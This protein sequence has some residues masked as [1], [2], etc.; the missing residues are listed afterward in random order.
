[1]KRFTK[2]LILLIFCTFSLSAVTVHAAEN[3]NT[4]DTKDFENEPSDDTDDTIHILFIGNSLTSYGTN[5]LGTILE[6]ISE[7]QGKSIT[8]RTIAHGAAH[9]SYYAYPSEKYASYYKEVQLALLTE[10]WDYIVLQEYSKGSIECAAKK[11]LPAIETFQELIK[12]YQPNAEILLYMTHGYDNGTTTYVNGNHV[13]LTSARLQQYTQIAY[14][15]IGE[16]LGLRVVPVGMTFARFEQLHPEISLISA[17]KK[18]PRYEGYFL[19][20]C[21]FYKTIFD[22]TPKATDCLPNGCMLSESCVQKLYDTT[23]GSLRLNKSSYIMKTGQTYDLKATLENTSDTDTE[24]TWKSTSPSVVDVTSSG[25]ITSHKN[26]TALIIAKSK[27]GL[28]DICYVTVEDELLHKRGLLFATESYV[29]EKGDTLQVSPSRSAALTTSV[30]K[31]SSSRKSIA[32]IAGD[33]TVTA[34]SPGKTVITATDTET[35]KSASYTLF[36]RLTAPQKVTA[37]TVT[38]ASNKSNE[39]NIKISWS[40][41]SKASKYTIYRSSSKN[42]TYTAIGQTSSRHFIDTKVRTGRNYYYK[43]SASN[44][45]ISCESCKSSA[46]ARVIAP[47]T[48]SIEKTSANSKKVKLTWTR[49][50]SASGYI[51]Y[52]STNNGKTYK[53]VART[54]SNAKT[55]YID[56][57]VRKNKNY[58]YKIKAYKNLNNLVFNS[59]FSNA[60]KVKAAP[61]SAKSKKSSASVSASR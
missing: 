41:V 3:K 39:A 1:M 27:S 14:T 58:C 60:V 55:S 46:Y 13:S 26:G 35:G 9:L 34:V 37:K 51:I 59:N 20:A 21:C 48:P 40:A 15:C 54:T 5:N 52:R 45:D 38:A 22:E 6:N 25:K 32:K 43:V 2:L 61:K 53:E 30:L 57:N 24:I 36:I 10:N 17:D 8:A 29:V 28:Q 33:G 18:H 56:N 50:T 44:G 16:Q 4:Y 7:S 19:A 23:N 49:K 47:T 11:T 42:G 31:W 12:V